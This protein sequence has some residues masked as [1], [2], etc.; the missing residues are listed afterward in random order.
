MTV[1]ISQISVSY[2]GGK[3][4]N[5]TPDVVFDYFDN[6]QNTMHTISS[7]QHELSA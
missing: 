6:V 5:G 7:S 2:G 1:S 4:E 3:I